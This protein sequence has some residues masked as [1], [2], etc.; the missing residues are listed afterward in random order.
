ME[1]G[2]TDAGGAEDPGGVARR[3]RP[4]GRLRCPSGRFKAPDGMFVACARACLHVTAWHEND[5]NRLVEAVRPIFRCPCV[6]VVVLSGSVA[7][8]SMKPCW[9][10]RAAMLSLTI[11]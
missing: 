3:M 4:V 9:P 8:L 2:D 7:M 11:L 5:Q 1:T 6:C 10:A